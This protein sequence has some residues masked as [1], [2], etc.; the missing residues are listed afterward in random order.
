V[1][2]QDDAFGAVQCW[3]GQAQGGHQG[4]S[5]LR[6]RRH[7]AWAAVQEL[8]QEPH[9][10]RFG[11]RY[12]YACAAIDAAI[13][14]LGCHA[15][16]YTTHSNGKAKTEFK[17]DT[18]SKYIAAHGDGRDLEDDETI[19]WYL[20]EKEQWNPAI[21]AS[22]RFVGTDH[23]NK[24]IVVVIE[25]LPMP[26]NRAIIPLV[27]PFDISKE[28]TTQAEAMK[29]WTKVPT[30]LGIPL[31]KTGTDP[32]RLFF[33]PR[34]AKGKPNSIAIW[35]GPL[36]DWRTLVLDDAFEAFGEELTRIGMHR[37]RQ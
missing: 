23:T 5:G 27:V 10:H 3:A 17:K 16:R 25:H 18:L 2:V 12:W 14:N 33:F 9:W 13:T 29:K 19:R 15:I 1:E 32:S 8:R 4:R 30:A 22:A 36:F 11:Y 34:H 26:K 31:D 7:G 21:V 37:Y 24:G 20:A 6:S 28:G 35:G